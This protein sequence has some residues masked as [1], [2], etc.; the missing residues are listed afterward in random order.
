MDRNTLMAI[1]IA[2]S[3]CAGDPFTQVSFTATDGGADALPE[4][5]ADASG[6]ADTAFADVMDEGDRDASDA[7]VEDAAHA[8][9]AID[10]APEVGPDATSDAVPDTRD[11]DTICIPKTCVSAAR[12]C[13]EFQDGCGGTLQCGL[14]PAYKSCGASGI[15]NVCGTVVEITCGGC[16]AGFVE[17]EATDGAC[18]PSCTGGTLRVCGKPGWPMPILACGESASGCPAGY[19][20]AESVADC[21]CGN[22]GFHW[23]CMK[24]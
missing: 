8:D 19:P 24:G 14:C 20:N 13:G 3:A 23:L 1:V 10:I 17:I 2:L 15:P 21:A 16:S 22:P 18:M 7:P 4:T 5:G 9:T 6:D 12:D 11:E